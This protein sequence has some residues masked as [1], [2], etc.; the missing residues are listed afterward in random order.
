[1]Q[2]GLKGAAQLRRVVV[3]QGYSG[4]GKTQ[5]AIEYTQ[6]HREDYSAIVWI[7]ARDETAI[8]QS[9]VR[10][11][12]WILNHDPSANYISDAV[13]SKIQ[14]EIVTAVKRWFDEP[15]NDSWLIIYNKYIYPDPS[16]IDTEGTEDTRDTKDIKDT[17]LIAEENASDT[18]ST[19]SIKAA[20]RRPFD[21]RKYI[22]ESNHG[23]IIVTSPRFL[24]KLGNCI[25][26]GL[27]EQVE[28]SLDIL[29]SSSCRENI[30]QGKQSQPSLRT[31]D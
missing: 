15:T 2:E 7:D 20:T 13:Q 6:R 23:A 1:M 11:A 17:S 26:I 29:S 28:D 12:T 18:D 10:L 27:F 9:F 30:R 5:L 14:N 8:N 21:I 19:N 31:I 4:R 22:P 16:I 25:S 3:L 24:S